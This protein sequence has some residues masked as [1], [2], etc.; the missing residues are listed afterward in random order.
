MSTPALTGDL[1]RLSSG[2]LVLPE[3]HAVGFLADQRVAVDPYNERVVCDGAE[4]PLTRTKLKLWSLFSSRPDEVLSRYEIYDEVWGASELADTSNAL[5]VYVGYL[6]QDV[7]PELGDSHTGV[8]RT[9]RGLGIRAV[10]SLNPNHLLT[11][12]GTTINKAADGRIE[13]RPDQ[14]V[15]LIDN[16]VY[17]GL[18]LTEFRLLSLL[19]SQPGRTF[20]RSFL[21]E[22]IWGYDLSDTSNTLGMT[23]SSVRRKLGAIDEEFRGPRTGAL[24]SHQYQGIYVPKSL[25]DRP[26]TSLSTL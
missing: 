2:Q 3:L 15:C 14:G 18:S 10:S 9:F 11:P 4:L 26:K 16:Q 8:L 12:E 5:G 22:E 25:D 23:V 17:E 19:T 1:E 13:T 24:R 20:S 21:F 6:R 7:G